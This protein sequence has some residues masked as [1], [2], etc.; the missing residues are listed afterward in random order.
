MKKTQYIFILLILSVGRIYAQLNPMGSI[1]FQNPYLANPS[2]A[3]IEQGW[4]ANLATKVQWTAI[5]GAP[6]MQSATLTY[7]AREKRIALGFNVYNENAG[8]FSRTTLKGTYAYHLPLTDNESFLDFGLSARMTR[9]WIDDQKVLADLT[10]PSINLFNSRKAYVDGDFG[11]AYRNQHLT[12]ELA[13]PDLQRFFNRDLIRNTIDRSLY[14]AAVGFKFTGR[15]ITA[16]PKAMYRVVGNYRNILDLAIE[17]QCMNDKLF[18]NAIYHSTN[19]YTLGIG[20]L[21]QKQLRILCLY[22]TGTSDLGK[23]SNGEFEIA[24]QYR[25][26]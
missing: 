6:A 15:N 4:I 13:I 10:D 19:S 18:F 25:L 16:E 17:F 9:E 3:G 22:T 23:Y 8:V 21:Y 26:K 1:Y 11:I 5:D 24:L 14:M 2:L 20:T 12:A 7:G